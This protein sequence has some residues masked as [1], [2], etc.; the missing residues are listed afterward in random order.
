MFNWINIEFMKTRIILLITLVCGAL[1]S[2]Y[3]DESSLNYKLIN[4]IVIDMGGAETSYSVFA[5][6]ELEI[7]PIVYKEGIDDS[8]LS[9]KWT[10][11]GN[12]IIPEVLDTTMT[13][14][15]VITAKP[16]SL[17]YNLLFQVVDK[18]TGIDHDSICLCLII[19][20][21]KPYCKKGY[22]QKK[23]I[24]HSSFFA[25]CLTVSHSG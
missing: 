2:C 5:Y 22:D 15:K 12:T 4:P 13:L 19:T 23:T 1:C 25:S 20:F 7:K 14:K 8:N 11:S 18:T 16:E 21:C 3:E 17:P 9:Y 24:T 10:L 6:K